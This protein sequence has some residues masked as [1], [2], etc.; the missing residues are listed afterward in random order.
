MLPEEWDRCDDPDD[1]VDAVHRGLLIL[2]DMKHPE[3]ATTTAARF[4]ASRKEAAWR[5]QR[6][7]QRKLRCWVAA[8]AERALGRVVEARSARVE[9]RTA[10]ILKWEREDWVA[11]QIER[12]HEAVGEVWLRADG[13]SS[14]QR[15]ELARCRLEARLFHPWTKVIQDAC[16][17]DV[18]LA[19]RQVA[20]FCRGQPEVATA[21]WAEQDLRAGQLR[22]LFG[23]PFGQ[24]VPSGKCP[25]C[26]WQQLPALRIPPPRRPMDTVLASVRKMDGEIFWQ[27]GCGCEGEGRFRRP[28]RTEALVGMARRIHEEEDWDALGVLAD[29]AE[30]N[31]C[32]DAVLLGHLRGAVLEFNN[33]GEAYWYT[34]DNAGGRHQTPDRARPRFLRGD[35]AL[36]LILGRD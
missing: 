18:F 3:P 19:A 23:S 12:L 14:D 28:W 35:W 17:P 1:M 33:G 11:A 16:T 9:F 31:G 22:C 4:A 10:G 2:L 20:G 7:V 36:D 27:P 21:E 34:A 26:G 13:G 32:T 6:I 24:A 8:C 29:M 25:E 15:L 5:Q 30:D